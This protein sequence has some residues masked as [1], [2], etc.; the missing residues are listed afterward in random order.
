[1]KA[2]PVVL[3][4]HSWAGGIA[5]LAASDDAGPISGLVLLASI[6]P[7]CLLRVDPVLAAPVLGEVIAYSAL[8]I[9]RPLIGRRARALLTGHI[10]TG[11]VPYAWASGMAMLRRTAWRSF[12]TEQRALVRGLADIERAL[13]D[14]E[15]P[16]HVISASNDTMIPRRTA[17]ALANAIPGATRAEIAGGHDLQLRRPV[18]V[19]EQITA[20]SDGLFD[21]AA[22]A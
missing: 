7:Y 9:A 14:V 22:H 21:P 18:E 10:A 8:R 13:P 6:G 16:T 2:G 15:V 1:V 11:D 19:A 4:G 12:L 5:V 3:V 20:F 17:E